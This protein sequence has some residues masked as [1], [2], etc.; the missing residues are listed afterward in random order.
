MT[1]DIDDSGID[2]ALCIISSER[3]AYLKQC[4]ESVAAAL[5]HS[6]SVTAS[7]VY[8]VQDGPRPRD[9]VKRIQD[10]DGAVHQCVMTF[11]ERFPLSQI[12]V[13][14]NRAH[15]GSWGHIMARRTILGQMRRKVLIVVEDDVVVSPCFIPA[16]LAMHKNCPEASSTHANFESLAS[17]RTSEEDVLEWR[18]TD[19]FFTMNY[20]MGLEVWDEIKDVTME[21]FGIIEPFDHY[22]ENWP[23][24]RVR[25]LYARHGRPNWEGTGAD[26]STHFCMSVRGLDKRAISVDVL[27]RHIG[28][29]GVHFTPESYAANEKI[30][31]ARISQTH[32]RRMKGEET[33]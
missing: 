8:L 20:A 32:F 26:A 7:D 3:P 11:A 28:R 5:P 33:K 27:A 18:Y 10:P 17:K 13:W 6:R 23:E 25:E 9:A 4:L 15:S 24:A 2:A 19:G 31:R 14:G 22:Q 12:L 1:I 16:I 29:S 21:Y 30:S